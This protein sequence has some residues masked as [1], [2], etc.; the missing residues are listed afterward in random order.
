MQQQSAAFGI[1]ISHLSWSAGISLLASGVA[2]MFWVV[3]ETLDGGAS[4][5]Y[6]YLLLIDSQPLFVKYGR[7]PVFLASTLISAAMCIWCGV[8]VIPRSIRVATQ[9]T[10]RCFIVP[11]KL[12]LPPFLRR[13]PL[14]VGS[15]GPLNRSLRARSPTSSFSTTE[16]RRSPCS[17]CQFSVA[18]RLV[19]CCPHIL[20][21][22]S[23]WIGRS[24]GFVPT[25]F[26][27]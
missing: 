6:L 11:P 2:T 7:R 9:S 20:F 4:S 1:P 8:Y 3:G 25:D 23:G 13:E 16:E 22:E 21:R 27:E 18:T 12:P 10:D 17:D 14:S 24:P 19:P 5:A 26:N 15:S